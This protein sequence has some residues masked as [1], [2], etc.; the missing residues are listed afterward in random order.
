M[1]CEAENQYA[2]EEGEVV[3]AWSREGKAGEHQEHD[4]DEQRKERE[5]EMRVQ[6]DLKS[7]FDHRNIF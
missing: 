4:V 6:N 3:R 7:R 5:V 2:V 1:E